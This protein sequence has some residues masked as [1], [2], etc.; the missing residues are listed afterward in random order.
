MEL[1]RGA[2]RVRVPRVVRRHRAD[3]ERNRYKNFPLVLPV[4]LSQRA[5]GGNARGDAIQPAGEHHPLAILGVLVVG[6]R[7][8]SIFGIFPSLRLHTSADVGAGSSVDSA[9]GR[10]VVFLPRMRR[11]NQV[12]RSHGTRPQGILGPHELTLR[13]AL[14]LA[15]AYFTGVSRV[16]HRVAADHRGVPGVFRVFV[17]GVATPRAVRVRQVLRKRRL[18]VPAPLFANN[19]LA[20]HVP[21]IYGFPPRRR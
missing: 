8:A 3:A 11:K 7:G 5:S 14:R 15:A 9:H 21:G 6:T 10:V 17:P 4:R 16:F 12:L 19:K 2:V 13:R 1:H 18:D 20:V